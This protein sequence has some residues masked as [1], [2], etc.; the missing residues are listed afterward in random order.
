MSPKIS[1]PVVKDARDRDPWCV[2]C[3]GLIARGVS[4]RYDLG[5]GP[6]RR[7]DGRHAADRAH[8]DLVNQT[9][10]G[11]AGEADEQGD[12]TLL[13]RAEQVQDGDPSDTSLTPSV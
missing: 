1:P 3:S 10:V 2:G 5:C 7:H 6:L 9:I 12:A 4:D 11:Q 8:R 13:E